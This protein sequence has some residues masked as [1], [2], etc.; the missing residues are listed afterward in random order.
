M[1]CVGYQ[2]VQED[3]VGQVDQVDQLQQSPQKIP[4]SQIVLVSQ[5]GKK[6]SQSRKKENVVFQCFDIVVD[7]L[8]YT[9]LCFLLDINEYHSFH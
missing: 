1:L 4:Q 6:C 9:I 7:A 5:M 2:D 3:R 8:V